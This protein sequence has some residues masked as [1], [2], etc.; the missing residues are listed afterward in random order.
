M[1]IALPEQGWERFAHMTQPEFADWLRQVA[2]QIDWARY[3]KS[4][5]APKKPVNRKKR[6]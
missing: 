4:K 5:R 2:R 3:I 6:S 1:D